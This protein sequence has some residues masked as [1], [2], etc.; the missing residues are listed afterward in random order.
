[1]SWTLVPAIM[2]A[3]APEMATVGAVL[4][5]LTV[6]VTGLSGKL[7]AALTAA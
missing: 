2:L 1:M 4:V 3:G 6:A 5:R 7:E